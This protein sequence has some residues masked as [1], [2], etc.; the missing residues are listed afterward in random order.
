MSNDCERW[1]LRHWFYWYTS[2]I[3]L[4]ISCNPP[5]FFKISLSLSHH[6]IIPKY[7]SIAENKRDFLTAADVS[8]MGSNIT[9]Q[10]EALPRTHG[11][12]IVLASCSSSRHI[13]SVLEGCPT[14]RNSF[15]VGLGS[16]PVFFFC[17][18][19][20][21]HNLIICSFCITLSTAFKNNI[22]LIL[23]TIP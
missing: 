14:F 10:W 15:G 6:P 9:Q 3:C 1:L 17:H 13:K 2:E 8:W 21:F 22:S 12:S 5:L 11:G 18:I 20:C 7:H 19:N 16:W 23:I 4:G